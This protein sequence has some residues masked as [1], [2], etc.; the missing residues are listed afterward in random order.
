LT[1]QLKYNGR[2]RFQGVRTLSS[3]GSKVDMQ[4][5][6][7]TWYYCCHRQLQGLSA[8]PEDYDPSAVVVV[9]VDHANHHNDTKDAITPGKQAPAKKRKVKDLQEEGDEEEDAVVS[10]SRSRRGPILPDPEEDVDE[11]KLKVFASAEAINQLRLDAMQ[12]TR[13]ILVQFYDT[14]RAIFEE[15][16]KLDAV[17]EDATTEPGAILER[18]RTRR[19]ME[20]ASLG[21]ANAMIGN[22]ERNAIV[23]S[24]RRIL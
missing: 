1:R 4:R 7:V 22:L 6:I 21:N 9:V 10:V 13:E 16:H 5:R 20:E 14:R 11:A 8:V 2:V 17:I 3:S 19:E 12:K 18:A 15:L 24:K 23:A